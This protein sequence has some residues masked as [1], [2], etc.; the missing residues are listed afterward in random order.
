MFTAHGN[1]NQEI[2]AVSTYAAAPSTSYT[3]R[4]YKNPPS[5]SPVSTSGPAAE[6]S[7]TFAESGYFT[8]NLPTPVSVAPGE[9][10]SV[11]VKVSTTS[12][13]TYLVPVEAAQ[14]N[15]SS[16]A[17][18]AS[19]RSYMSG[20]GTSWTDMG[21]QGRDVCVKAFARAAGSAPADPDSDG[22]GLD[23]AWERQYFG[24]LSQSG[25]GDYDRDGLSNLKEYE[26]GTNPANADT[27]GDGMPDGWE[28]THGLNPKVNDAAGDPDGDGLTNLQ[29]YKG[30]TDPNKAD[31]AS[32]GG[33]SGG[34]DSG[35]DDSGGGSDGGDTPDGGGTAPKPTSN[36]GQDVLA[37]EG[38]TVRL[39]GATGGVSGATLS[40]TQTSGPSVSLSGATTDRPTFTAPQVG[41]NGALLAFR[42]TVTAGGQSATDT[43]LVR[44]MDADTPQAAAGQD[45]HVQ[46][47]ERVTL[48]GTRSRH[49]Q[50]GAMTY[51]WEQ[52]GAPSVQLDNP[53]AA[54]ASFTAPGSPA[55][56]TFKL[57]V[58][59][60]GS[61]H[62]T[63]DIC[64]VFVGL[65][66]TPPLAE[67]GPARTAQPGSTVT[68]DGSASA[69]R[70]GGA[71]VS[72]AWTQVAGTAVDLIDADTDK[73]YFK[74]PNASAWGESL[75]FELTV[76]DAN[77]LSGSD[78]AVVN[79][80]GSLNPAA[81][82]ARA[83][84][85]AVVDG[86]SEYRPDAS[87]SSDDQTE[88]LAYEWLQIAGSPVT[89][90]DPASATPVI[91]LAQTQGKQDPVLRLRVRDKAGL[92]GEDELRLVL[93]EPD[94][95]MDDGTDREGMDIP[96][97]EGGQSSGGGGGCVM[98]SGAG[99][100][101]EW[102]LLAAA[103]MAWRMRR[104]TRKG[105]R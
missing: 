101:L 64:R 29:E 36:A 58:S 96:S 61:T 39:S 9:R 98:S 2:F 26:L 88:S 1:T 60:P 5:N 93:G 74:A 32:G 43:C 38:E 62:A 46:P 59:K 63:T 10:F 17:S 42:L 20:N 28:V 4:V 41:P 7:G 44:V 40:W 92:I 81:P 12:G 34:G 86:L 65:D 25:A 76:T 94:E 47:G 53:N 35:G 95:A 80:L 99:M 72:H 22:D 75:I 78:Q 52:I 82:K 73:P 14:S 3:I 48:D 69:A 23:D 18:S 50:G 70:G 91:G 90:D 79:V 13:T 57:T 55:A 31:G 68:L 30:G 11:V 83:G 102:F 45:R 100:G 105:G 8:V 49:P 89:L 15:Y 67:A 24:D 87:A 33:D 85:D 84:A 56:L 97:G 51:L 77:G 71:I 21:A 104:K 103:A 66:G 6:V 37:R 54:T 27:D 16:K 19:G